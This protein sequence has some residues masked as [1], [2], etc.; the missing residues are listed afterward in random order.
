M[1]GPDGFS[2][3]ND[4]F[5]GIDSGKVSQNLSQVTMIGAAKLVFYDNQLFFWFIY[6]SR[7]DIGSKIPH[8]LLYGL[9]LQIQVK[10]FAER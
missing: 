3:P 9:H 6:I 5:R 10:S 2:Y 7:K 8:S 4:C 1:I